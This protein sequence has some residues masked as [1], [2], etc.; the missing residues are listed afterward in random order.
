MLSKSLGNSVMTAAA[1]FITYVLH[2]RPSVSG[3]RFFVP[4]IQIARFTGVFSFSPS[5]R[6]ERPEKS[7]ARR[8]N[9]SQEKSSALDH[10][11]SSGRN[12]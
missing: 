1:D 8:Q 5:P 4:G 2:T 7:G 3:K 11:E 6:N 9:D 10:V 12:S